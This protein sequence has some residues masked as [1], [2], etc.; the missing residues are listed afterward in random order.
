MS[1]CQLPPSVCRPAVRRGPGSIRAWALVLMLALFV[2]AGCAVPPPAPP[3]PAATPLQQSVDRLTDVVLGQ[4]GRLRPSA[5]GT[6]ALPVAVGPTVF[7]DSGPDRRALPVPAPV[8]RWVSERVAG[9]HREHPLVAETDAT[10]RLRLRARIEAVDEPHAAAGPAP[11]MLT[12]EALDAVEGAV[13]VAASERVIDPVLQSLVPPRQAERP[14]PPPPPLPENLQALNAEYVSLLK[15]GKETEAQAVFKRI[16]TEGLATRNLSVRLLFAPASSEFYP[17]PVLVR[18]YGSWLSEVA[19]Q[20]QRSTHCLEIVGHASRTGSDAANRRLSQQR[21]VA[22]R[23]ILVKQ[24]PSLAPRLS[25]SALGR[26]QT[27]VGSGT[28]DLRDAVDRRVELRVVDC[29]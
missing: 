14:A 15:A 20:L 17:D 27:L 4:L 19:D 21:A 23:Q 29:P 18:R 6:A 25:T 26:A 7:V 9:Q 13:L 3:A 28:D 16:V 10:A 8:S 12:L 24:A 11:F 5:P 1:F 2:L 22:V